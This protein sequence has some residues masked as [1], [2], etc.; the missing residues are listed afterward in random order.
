MWAAK[1]DER[2][3]AVLVGGLIVL[4]WA[5]LLAWGGS[6]YG[7]VLGHDGLG[8]TDL[9]FDSDYAAKALLF[10][11]GWSLMT[12]AMM[13]PTSLPLVILFHTMTHSR[14]NSGILIL[15]LV[16]GYLGIWV[17]FGAVAHVAD[18]WLHRFVESDA[19]LHSNAWLIGAAPLL[20]AGVYQFTALKYHCLDKCRS[21]YSF[22]VEHWRGGNEKLQAVR[23]GLHH[24]VFCVGCCWSLMLL[25]FAVGV[26][27]VVWMLA[28]AVVMG[29]EKNMPW[30]RRLS[31]P[32]GV[33][34]VAAGLTVVVANLNVS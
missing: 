4:A 6:P 33:V 3:F 31:A 25:M 30:G 28:L 11:S 27:S 8:Q 15:L 12:V 9:R 34:L 18:F 13:L 2:L 23:L 26:G 5:A 29:T 24:G 10:V 1:S 14:H 22:I 7:S 32:L 16:L 20:V 17:A 19:W 21:P